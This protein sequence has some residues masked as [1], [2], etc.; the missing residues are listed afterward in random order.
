MKAGL[1]LALAGS[2]MLAACGGGG[3]EPPAQP[4]SAPAPVTQLKDYQQAYISYDPDSF[5]SSLVLVS[6]ANFTQRTPL[7]E[8]FQFESVYAGTLASGVV[9]EFRPHSLFYVQ[10]A[11][12]KRV[13]LRSASP[14]PAQVSNESMNF[15]CTLRSLQPT[16]GGNDVVLLYSKPGVD[17]SCQTGDDVFRRVGATFSAT[18]T[19]LSGPNGHQFMPFYDASGTLV[20]VIAY[21]VGT[22]ALSRY[23]ADLVT[24]TPIVSGNAFPLARSSSSALMVV[25]GELRHLSSLGALTGPLHTISGA[26]DDGGVPDD[27]YLYFVDGPD[28]GSPLLYRVALDGSQSSEL[29]WSPAVDELRV[30]GETTDSLVLAASD[31]AGTQVLLLDKAT[32]GTATPVPLD[33]FAGVTGD[34]IWVNRYAAPVQY[35]VYEAGGVSA[36]QISATDVLTSRASS[37]WVGRQFTVDYPLSA[38]QSF[39]WEYPA[40]GAF[41]VDDI[42]S[43]NHQ[44]ATVKLVDF[45]TGSATAL[46]T[47]SE[48][49]FV[50]PDA[51]GSV[52]MAMVYGEAPAPYY[53]SY[54]VLSFDLDDGRIER[55]TNA[56]PA[57]EFPHTY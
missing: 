24:S 27:N 46:T 23:A 35:N 31:I 38:L 5:A 52:G 7:G 16:F 28:G 41:R 57:L 42:V 56:T 55:H 6:A 29:L 14:A 30:I 15:A 39:R 50:Y 8:A 19:P 43:D 1:W 47:V 4:P 25:N 49:G 51:V 44:G 13:D 54:D 37:E 26:L 12:L 17:G 36:H 45:A 20:S 34:D 2:A 18:A 9:K 33:S 22:G 40:Q 3:D 11:V 21:H 10:D 53:Y 48:F 32:D